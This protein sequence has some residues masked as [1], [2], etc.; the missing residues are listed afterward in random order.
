MRREEW[1]VGV[2]VGSAVALGLVAVFLMVR[3]PGDRPPGPEHPRRRA[4]EEIQ[5]WVGELQ[6][7]V[8]GVLCPVWGDPAPDRLYEGNLN[9]DLGLEG[10]RALG[11]LPASGLQHLQGTPDPVDR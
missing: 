4:P 1:L 11:V 2:L 9:R 3:Q 5:V 10:E 8:V 6:P 7:G